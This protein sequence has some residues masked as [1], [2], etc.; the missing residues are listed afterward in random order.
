MLDHLASDRAA[1]TLERLVNA[2]DRILFEITGLEK[3]VDDTPTMD[4]SDRRELKRRI[5]VLWREA[6]ALMQ[7]VCDQREF[8]R[9]HN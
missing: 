7:W 9:P 6:D 3:I 2:L 8:D 1:P 5:D 4:A